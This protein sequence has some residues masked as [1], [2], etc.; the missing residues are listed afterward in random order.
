MSID[1]SLLILS[2]ARADQPAANAV[3]SGTLYAVTDEDLLI[4]RSNGVAWSQYG[5][6]PGGGGGG[7]SIIAKVT[8][9]TKTSD[10][11]LANDGALIY[12]AAANK[13]IR[14]HANIRVTVASATPDI[15]MT[16]VGPAGATGWWVETY[17]TTNDGDLGVNN[18]PGLSTYAVFIYDVTVIT[19]ATPGTVAFQWAQN[20][21][22]ADATTV[23]AGS[24]MSVFSN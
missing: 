8:D 5:P 10:T 6:T 22:S 18:A 13:I 1:F 3:K 4:E 17:W 7:G 12:S 14:L 11:T 16:W 20:T 15:K 19:D 21:S 2:G 24:N 9:E 23:K